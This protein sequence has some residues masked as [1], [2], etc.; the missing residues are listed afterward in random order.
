LILRDARESDFIV[1]VRKFLGF[2]L[3]LGTAGA[4]SALTIAGK[5]AKPGPMI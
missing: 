5:E 3:L 2:V 1:R 4:A